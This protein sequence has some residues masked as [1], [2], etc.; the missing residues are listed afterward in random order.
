MQIIGLIII[1]AAAGRWARSGLDSLPGLAGDERP[2]VP[3]RLLVEGGERA[4][5]HL[6]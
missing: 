4:R 2:S 6:A 5:V 1:G 3:G